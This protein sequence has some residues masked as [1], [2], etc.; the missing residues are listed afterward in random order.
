MIQGDTKR[1]SKQCA[2]LLHTGFNDVGERSTVGVRDSDITCS[3][4]CEQND[5][6]S[7]FACPMCSHRCPVDTHGSH[8]DQA[9][10][11]RTTKP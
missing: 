10:M 3:R 6:S 11:L 1:M 9:L 4:R 8:N 2:N 5:A 7:A